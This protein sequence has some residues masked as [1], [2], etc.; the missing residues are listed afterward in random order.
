MTI[1]PPKG[2]AEGDKV[3]LPNGAVY[4]VTRQRANSTGGYFLKR[5]NND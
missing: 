2:L 4:I 3:R 1:E 5:I